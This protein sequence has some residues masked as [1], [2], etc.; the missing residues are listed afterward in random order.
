MAR[1][2]ATIAAL[3]LRYTGCTDRSDMPGLF[4]TSGIKIECHKMVSSETV[5]LKNKGN[6]GLVRIFATPAFGPSLD[7]DVVA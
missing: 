5:S 4:T 3:A 6:V 7:S 1:S 2:G